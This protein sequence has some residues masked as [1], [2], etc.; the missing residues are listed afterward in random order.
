MAVNY[1]HSVRLDR[2]KCRGC[3]NCIKRCPTEAIRIR[4]GKAF[5][6]EERCID[7]GECIRVCQNHAKVVYTDPWERLTEVSRSVALP[8]P[9]FFG[10]F[11]PEVRP[12]QVIAAFR[13]AGFDAVYEVALAADAVG[14]AIKRYLREHRTPRPLISS[15][16]P[17]VVRLIQVRFPGLIQHII[18]IESPMEMAARLAK[19]RYGEAVGTFF[20]TPCPAKVTASKQPVGL[21]QSA[22][23]GVISATEAYRRLLGQVL[24]APD[25]AAAQR[26]SGWGIGWGRS[27]GECI[28][29]DANTLAVDGIHNV[30][31]VLD[32]VERGKLRDVDYLEAQACTS[33]CVG[34]PLA[35][36][37]PFVARVRIR[38]LSEGLAAR[39]AG[40]G[41][42]GLDQ[43]VEEG[44]F[45]LR[46][47]LEPRPPSPLDQDM[48]VAIAKMEQLERTEEALP[49]LDCGACGAPSCRALAEDIV[50]GLAVKTDCMFELRERVTELA[51][52]LAALSRQ[53]P[54]AMGTTDNHGKRGGKK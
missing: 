32:E 16:C 39:A 14:I 22:V 30:I 52:E 50:R 7:C 19:A 47:P 10:Q 40:D 37:N 24:K 42:E 1:F 36:E 23:D 38:R 8:A 35:V 43:L 45:Q 34:G 20:I 27:G 9:S 46:N 49:G 21:S 54:P 41:I 44:F 25:D 53:A 3:T 11:R 5:I 51:E 28:G 26:A 6:F 12:G 2:D 18:P 48:A 13:D 17:A 29:L 33:G 15:A 4:D 31:S